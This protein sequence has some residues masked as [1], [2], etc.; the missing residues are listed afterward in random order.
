[1]LAAG[2]VWPD[3]PEQARIR[4]VRSITP[5]AV[6][7]KPS[8]LKKL[9]GIISGGRERPAMLQPYGIAA[10]PNGKV[11]V[12]DTF[13]GCIHVYDIAKKEYS[14]IRVDAGALIGVVA[15]GDRLY[16]T[17][18]AG[19]AVFCIDTK[20]RRVWRV[21]A[22]A[23]L[24]RPAG[25]ALS[26][27]VLHVIDA[28][29]HQVVRIDAGGRVLGSHGTRG[30]SAGQFNFP[31]NIA[32]D[33]EGRFY[34]CDTMNFRVQVF[35][36]EWRPMAQWGKAGDGSGDFSKSKGI[37]IDRDGHIYVVEGINDVVQIFDRSGRLLLFFGGSGHE[38]GMFWL[39]TGIAI[40]GDSIYVADSANRRVQMFE[41]LGDG[42]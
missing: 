32:V 33:A 31:T 9:W 11:Y 25:L 24:V 17:D 41:Y 14:T 23:G 18:S 27:G 3:P 30:R 42:R 1:M 26:D 13:G 39:P 10:G 6:R 4:F 22:E 37:A 40:S 16:I 38:D 28:G 5:D 20:G 12:A 35:D 29:A 8:F 15:L 2:P 36:S 34:V 7:G 21:G 19:P